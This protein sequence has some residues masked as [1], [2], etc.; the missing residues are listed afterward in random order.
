MSDPSEMFTS[1]DDDI[2]EAILRNAY[3]GHFYDPS[4]NNGIV[5]KFVNCANFSFIYDDLKFETY[6]CAYS[7]LGR[8]VWLYSLWT[9][10]FIVDVGEIARK[11]GGTGGPTMAF[12]ESG[13]LVHVRL[14]K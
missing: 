11:F 6:G 3:E 10:N 13:G 7:R 12:F 8:G 5:G 14:D 2:A 9:R 4:V 1:N